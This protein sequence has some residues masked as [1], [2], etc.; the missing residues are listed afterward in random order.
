MRTATGAS[1]DRPAALPERQRD[2]AWA[3]PLYDPALRYFL[4]VFETGSVDA[5]ARRLD[6]ARSA[7]SRQTTRLEHE[8]GAPL[9]EP[10]STGVVATE[11]G[12][13][14]AGFARRVVR[15]AVA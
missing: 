6:V 15:D 3:V 8:V 1:N 7:I 5:A 12:H 9:F 2:V 4:E 11:A 10:R 13:V 14:F